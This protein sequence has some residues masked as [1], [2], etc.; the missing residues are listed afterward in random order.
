MNPL[1]KENVPTRLRCELELLETTA[2]NFGYRLINDGTVRL[3][4]VAAIRK[5][6]DEL[7][8]AYHAGEYTVEQAAELANKLRNKIMMISRQHSSDLGR[9][10]AEY[11]KPTGLSFEVVQQKVARKLFSRNFT[12]LSQVER[13]KVY[14]EIVNS[15]SRNNS[16]ATSIASYFKPAG[17]LLIVLSLSIVTYDIVYAKNKGKAA[18][19]HGAIAGGSMT[20]SY[21][22]GATAGLACGPGAPVCV[23]LGAFIGGVLGAIGMQYLMNKTSLSR[24]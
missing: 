23:G 22:V 9:A 16:N 24:Y 18:A 2:L 1:L 12:K 14:L 21:V 10:I 17:R 5:S 3:Q 8:Q 7:I 4:Y 13:G 15:S 19:Y 20:S 6:A 11:K